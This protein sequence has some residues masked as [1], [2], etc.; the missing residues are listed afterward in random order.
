M[1][2]SG[3]STS[4]RRLKARYIPSFRSNETSREQLRENLF[5]C[6]KTS[7]NGARLERNRPQVLRRRCHSTIAATPTLAAAAHLAL[8]PFQLLSA[9]R[10]GVAREDRF[11]SAFRYRRAGGLVAG[12]AEDLVAH[13]GG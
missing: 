2:K 1:E 5:L 3:I 7:R 4:P 8:D 11:E 6:H 12:Q 10:A 13:L 9:V